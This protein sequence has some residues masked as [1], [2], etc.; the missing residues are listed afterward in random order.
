MALGS[1]W[2]GLALGRSRG[3]QGLGVFSRCS[4]GWSGQ[5][6]GYGSLPSPL[7]CSICPW[8]PIPCFSECSSHTFPVCK[9]KVDPKTDETLHQELV[10]GTCLFIESLLL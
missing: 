3:S 8:L 7:T 5:G 4:S 1:P 6:V 2:P 9:H 10:D